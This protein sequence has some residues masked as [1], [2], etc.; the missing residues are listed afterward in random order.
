MEPQGLC[1]Q[2]KVQVFQ[3]WEK[4]VAILSLGSLAENI[5]AM[6]FLGC[7]TA[8]KV[9]E[10]AS[11]AATEHPCRPPTRENAVDQGPQ[12]LPCET[13][14][15]VCAKATLPS[16]ASRQWPRAA[17]ILAAAFLRDTGSSDPRLCL[18]D[19]AVCW[20]FFRLQGSLAPFPP[21]LLSLAPS[22]PLD[23][24]PSLLWVPPYFFSQE[25]FP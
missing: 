1:W 19:S 21:N 14:W 10:L 8:W 17:G 20:T 23:S 11:T 5:L 16:G 6:L 22:S 3:G 13:H 12:L 9:Q 7:L 15:C 18:Q 25:H 2:V 4:R 24:S